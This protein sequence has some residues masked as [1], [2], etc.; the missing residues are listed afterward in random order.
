MMVPDSSF[1]NFVKPFLKPYKKWLI[2]LAIFPMIWCLVETIAPFLIKIII[3]HLASDLSFGTKTQNILLYTVFSYAFLMLALEVATRSCGYVWIKTFPKIRADMQTMVLKHIQ[4]RDYNFFYNQLSGDLISKYRN[5]TTS[6]ENI[7]KNLLYGFYPTTLSFIFS[8]IFIAFINSFFSII[9]FFWFVAMNLVTVFFFRKSIV[10]SQEQAKRQNLLL[11]YVGDFLA[12]AITMI[13]YPRDL[14]AEEGFLKLKEKGISSTEKSEFVTFK[15]DIWRSFFSWI[16]LVSMI[17]FLSF[18][19]QN[20]WISVGDFS[21]I[22]AICFYMRR[23]I[24]M[25]SSQLSDFFKEI[26]TAKE[27]LSLLLDVHQQKAVGAQKSTLMQLTNTIDFSQ[28]RFG[29]NHDRPLFNNLT[30]QI[31]P[32]QKLGVSGS[33]GAGKTSLIHLLLR[34]HDPDQGTIMINGE[35]YKDL[36]VENLRNF[37]SYVPQNAMLFHRSV[38]D[39][40]AFG[41]VAASK[42]EVYEAAKICLCDE[43]IH[44]LE[45]GYDTI[46]GEGGHKL[47]GG[48]RQRIAIARAYL[49]KAPVFILDEATSALD[50]ELEEKLLDQLLP[51]LQ[52]HTIILISH[53]ASSLEKMDRVIQFK[54]GQ[55]IQDSL[56]D[57]VI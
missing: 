21:F 18:G 28:I 2:A 12:N 38:F 57:E 13:A 56:Q 20:K 30:F 17:A 36:P 25:T 45:H 47:S 27:A 24:W 26:G 42:E 8:L 5:L 7:S 55:I 44:S 19:W 52:D 46:V 11:G 43:F 49:K 10:A 6:F 48:Q 34:L 16:L 22:A 50:F 15:A 37:F 23:S 54:H 32:G 1:W 29:Y 33:S 14:Y 40:I 9:F 39:N 31:S 35:N 41:K 53:R 4:A 3:D 51:K